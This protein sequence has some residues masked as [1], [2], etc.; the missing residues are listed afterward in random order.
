MESSM[1][2]IIAAIVGVLMF[3][4]IPVYIAFEK[5]DDISYTLAL[6]LTQNFVD[7]VRD[8]GYISPEMYSEFVSGLYATGNSYDIEIQHIKKRYDPA[9]Y[10]YSA[11]KEMDQYGNETG[12][13]TRGTV[14]SILDYAAYKEDL[15]HDNAIVVGSTTYKSGENCYIEKA[16]TINEEIITD[17]QIVDKLFKNTGITKSKFLQDCLLGNI[18]TYNTA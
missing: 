13:Y 9:I 2:K 7:N 12:R 15:D 10:V 17:K 6:K 11:A 16:H 1:Q 3:F 14:I 18:E 5:I 4:I 8:K